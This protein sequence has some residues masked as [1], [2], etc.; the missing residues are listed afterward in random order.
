MDLKLTDKIALVTGSGSPIGYG[1][2]IA[3]TLA[4]EGCHVACAD[5]DA[6]WAEE[7]A[8]AVEKL[9]RQALGV[10]VDVADRA[11]VDAMAQAVV[12]KFGR[13]DILVNNA[14]TSSPDKPFMMKTK[15]DWDL[16]IGVNLYGQMNVAQA[17]IPFMAQNGYG[18]I[19]NTSGGQ[20]IPTVSTYGAAKAGVEAWTHALALEVAGMGI[21]VNGITPGLGATGLNKTTTDEHREGFKR[22]SALKRLCA[23]EDV[24]PAVAFLASDTCSYMVGQWIK[25]ATF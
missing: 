17:V 21:I 14:G 15:A 12:A 1:R 4:E 16:D 20:G 7:A 13:I 8:A 9:G 5:L 18:R 11:S 25:L 6:A 10:G 3:L 22:M 2:A 19:V 24:A 23:P